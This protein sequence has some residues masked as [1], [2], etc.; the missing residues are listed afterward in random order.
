VSEKKVIVCLANS[1]KNQD[2]CVAGIEWITGNPG[3][4]IRPV[5]ARDGHGVSFMERQIPGGREPAPLDILEIRL[6]AAQPAGH[7]VENWLLDPT[8]SWA[9]VG[10]WSWNDLRHLQDEPADLWGTGSS[11]GKGLNDRVIESVAMRLRSSLALIHVSALTLHVL[12]GGFQQVKR[13]V[14]AIFKYHRTAYN[15]KVTDPICA[16]YYL[17]RADGRY[18]LGDCYLTV[19]LAESFQGFCYKV[20]AAVLEPD[21]P[22]EVKR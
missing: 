14:R 15:L 16:D 11:S 6:L 5:T 9:K 21:D 2:R 22:S 1:W 18:Q 4:W 7:Q 12:D 13:E 19:S 17:S 10:E 8:R 20:V 3:N